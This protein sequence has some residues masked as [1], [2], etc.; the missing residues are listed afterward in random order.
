[1]RRA[2][3]RVSRAASLLALR[4]IGSETPGLSASDF[5]RGARRC[6]TVDK[7]RERADALGR[8]KNC[9]EASRRAQ[10]WA[11]RRSRCLR[12]GAPVTRTATAASAS[13]RFRRLASPRVSHSWAGLRRFKKHL[14]RLRRGNTC[15]QGID[16]SRASNHDGHDRDHIQIRPLTSYRRTKKI[17]CSL[18]RSMMHYLM[19]P[20]RCA[21]QRRIEVDGFE[22]PGG[23]Q[24]V[25]ARMSP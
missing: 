12:H 15:E 21:E 6:A 11:A 16:H 24:R 13:C 9:V 1:M 18:P 25:M 8:A 5:E 3:P 14:L 10:T 23:R 4:G 2:S 22:F 17:R 20:G 19:L 7:V